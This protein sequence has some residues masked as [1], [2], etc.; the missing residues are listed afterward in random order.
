MNA[1]QFGGTQAQGHCTVIAILIESSNLA[2]PHAQYK[3]DPNAF[4]KA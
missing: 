2:M 4:W 1:S 3:L